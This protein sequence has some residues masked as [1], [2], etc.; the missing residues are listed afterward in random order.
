MFAEVPGARVLIAE[1][2][3]PGP[4]QPD[5]AKLFDI[6]MMAV[7]TAR[8]LVSEERRPA[9]AFAPVSPALGPP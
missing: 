2:V 1:Y 7:P 4:D 6:H 8:R 3:V 5:F 9:P